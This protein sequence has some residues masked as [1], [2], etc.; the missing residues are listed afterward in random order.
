MHRQATV[1]DQASLALHPTGA[2]AQRKHT[3]VILDA[4]GNL[5]ARDAGGWS[6]VPKR[7]RADIAQEERDKGKQNASTEHLR[8][9]EE[10]EEEEEVNE[11]EARSEHSDD[12]GLLE[13]DEEDE[14]GDDGDDND[15]SKARKRARVSE[16]G[17]ARSV[18]T[19]PHA[20]IRVQTLPRDKDG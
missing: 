6:G 4:R 20:R 1:Y 7:A 3:N 13:E 12:E 5:I 18:K 17:E 9:E 19:D 15:S 2:R 10:E 11:E 16:D 8:M 14:D